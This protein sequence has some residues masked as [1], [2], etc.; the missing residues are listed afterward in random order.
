MFVHAD[1]SVISLNVDDF[2]MVATDKLER[3]HWA[4]IGK[5]IVFKE[6][7]APLARYL[8]V[9]YNIDEF[10]LKQPDR[11]RRIRVSVANYLLALVARFQDDHPDAKLYPV[12]SPYLPEAQW[13]DANDQPGVYQAQCASCVASALFASLA[14]R[15]DISTAVRRLTTRVT[16]WTVPDD[17]ALLRLM[18][19][20][21]A[22]AS[23]E[24]VGTLS[25]DDWTALQLE[26]SPD[27][28]WNGDACTTRSVSGM[29]LE[30]V[31]PKSG[32]AFPLAW[33]SSGQSATSCSTAESEVVALSHGLRHVG[34]PVQDLVQEFLGERIPLVGLVDNQQAITA[35]KRVYSKRLR[36][37]N[38]MHRI[39]IGS[40]PEIVG[41]ERQRV[42]IRYIES[43][44]QKGSNYTK[45]M[46]PAQFSAERLLIGMQRPS[47]H[48]SS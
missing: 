11:A 18:A 39:A 9:N 15:P 7:A 14:G 24:L 26:L 28:D 45:A 46:V 4:E 10:S 12:T 19:Y 41:D 17:A 5:H 23:L 1:M 48:S 32:N 44:L 42:E 40:L 8:G 2:M 43:K 47:N 13:A 36:C 25:P 22:E 38:R 6:E 29:H 31:N 3:R 35:V 16:R 30:L 37:L 21:K 33:R 27:A 34:L 20:L